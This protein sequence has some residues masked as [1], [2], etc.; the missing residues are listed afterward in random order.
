MLAVDAEVV[1]QA[2]K[3]LFHGFCVSTLDGLYGMME[4]GFLCMAVRFV[5]RVYGIIIPIGVIIG[6]LFSQ[7]NITGAMG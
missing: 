6:D 3:L 4:L 1:L 2:T 5:L 7:H